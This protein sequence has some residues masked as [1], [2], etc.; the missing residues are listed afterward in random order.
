MPL[1]TLNPSLRP[2]EVR[3]VLGQ[4]RAAGLFLLR[5]YRGNPMA[6]TVASLHGE[7]PDLRE[8]VLFEEWESF[9]GSGSA[10]EILPEVS[11]DAPAQIQY[12]SGTTGRP[13]GAVLHH[14]GITNNA[15]LAY[16]HTLGMRP[17]EAVVNPMP[18]FH[19][20]GCVLATLSSIASLCTHV[21]MPYFDPSLQLQL[22]ASERSV[23]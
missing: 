9:C 14:R 2:A 6:Q 16:V 12:T 17:G 20:A 23:S 3:H 18:L 4:C 11:P 5:E 1:V 10:A 21:P 22:I 13:K 15:R 7:L 19:T 8:S